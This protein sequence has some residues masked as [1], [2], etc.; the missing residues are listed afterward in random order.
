MIK[1]TAKELGITE[2]QATQI[3]T[4]TSMVIREIMAEGNPK[5]PE[6]YKRVFLRNIGTYYV[7]PQTIYALTQKWKTT[8]DENI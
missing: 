1:E 6:K 5:E 7:R 4:G 3:W 2:L 8:Q